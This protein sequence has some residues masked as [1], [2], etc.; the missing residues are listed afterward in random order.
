MVISTHQIYHHS[1]SSVHS[2]TKIH[3]RHHVPVVRNR[4]PN[5]SNTDRI[6][7]FHHGLCGSNKLLYK[8]WA[9][10]MGKGKFRPTTAPAF[11]DRLSWNSNLRNTSGRPPYMPNFVKIGIRVWAG[12][13]P[14]LSQFWFYPLFSFFCLCILRIASWSY[15]W[16]D[17]DAR[18]L[19]GRV[20][21]Q[22]S[23]FW[24]LDDKRWCLGVKTPQNV[25]FG[26]PNRRFKPNLQNLRLTISSKLQNWSTWN[27]NTGFQLP[28]RLRGWSSIAT[29]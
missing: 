25:D 26:G 2:N 21:R 23:A 9:L 7:K 6:A 22:C 24:G 19:I 12:Q 8:R 15:R 20:F 27:L 14:S 18:W 5:P 11:I 3:Y 1:M 16:T 28:Y 17:Y 4:R 10:S 13:T 29:H